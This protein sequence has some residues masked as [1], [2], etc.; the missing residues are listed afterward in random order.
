MNI[1]FINW[2]ADYEVRMI[3]YLKEYYS[4]FSVYVPE[5]YVWFDKQLKKL[6]LKSCWLGK[7]FI[8]KYLRDL[9]PQDVVIFNDSLLNKGIN[10]Y[11]I[12]AANC[13]RVLLLRNSVDE[14]YINKN[15]SSFDL[16]YDFECKKINNEKIKHLEQFFPIGF[17]ELGK[18]KS[19]A[20][21]KNKPVFFFL[22]REKGRFDTISKL[23]DNL[24]ERGFIVDFNI[25]KDKKT[26]LS[27]KY[28]IDKPLSYKENIKRSLLSDVI[29]DITQES[30][31]GWTLRVLESLYF[32]KK[33]ITN[34]V[35]VLKSSIYS[36]QRFFIL[37][38]DGWDKLDNFINSPV[39]PV[40]ETILRTFSPDYMIEKIVRDIKNI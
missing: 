8:K 11:V 36:P 34:N 37:D 29:I 2:K 30:Q 23:A 15:C 21:K 24:I 33:I 13:H 10:Q 16:I 31:S 5:R 4:I 9:Q 35:N 1:Y 38:Y 25:V 7:L 3:N 26:T 18:F 28:F 27:S 19:V 40:D 20:A 6:G 32:N 14:E 17:E 22:G 12:D 39:A